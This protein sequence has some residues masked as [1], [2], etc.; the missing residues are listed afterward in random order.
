[1][2]RASLIFQSKAPSLHT[3]W[4]LKESIQVKESPPPFYGIWVRENVQG[5]QRSKPYK[6]NRK[7]DKDPEKRHGIQTSNQILASGENDITEKRN[8]TCEDSNGVSEPAP[9]GAPQ[10]LPWLHTMLLT[11]GWRKGMH[12]VPGGQNTHSL[13]PW[14]LLGWLFS[15]PPNLYHIKTTQEA[16]K[17][18]VPPILLSRKPRNGKLT[19]APLERSLCVIEVEDIQ[20]TMQI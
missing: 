14:E 5:Q 1:M 9:V 11:R 8:F 2:I 7:K 4:T 3:P 10:R 18:F 17:S 19:R 12:E 20:V 6:Q 15:F 16:F 13:K